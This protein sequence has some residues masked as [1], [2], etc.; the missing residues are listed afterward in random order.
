MLEQSNLSIVLALLVVFWVIPAQA[1]PVTSLGF[2][3]PTKWDNDTLFTWEVLLKIIESLL[4]LTVEILAAPSSLDCPN[5]APSELVM[6]K[7]C[8]THT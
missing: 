2:F 6:G 5:P 4:L 8:A 3:V 1:T 7:N